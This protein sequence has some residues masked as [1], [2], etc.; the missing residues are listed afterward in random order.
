M[1]RALAI[2]DIQVEVAKFKAWLLQA[3][4]L[5]AREIAQGTVAA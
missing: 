5:N 3:R 2:R 1:E 4:R